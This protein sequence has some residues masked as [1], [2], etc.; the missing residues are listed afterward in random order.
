[1]YR[2]VDQK[3][4]DGEVANSSTVTSD[5]WPLHNLVGFTL[6]AI[7]TGSSIA[8]TAAI[9][10]SNDGTNWVELADS[11][12]ALSDS[13]NF[14]WEVSDTYAK[15]MRVKIVE[16]AGNDATCNVYLHARGK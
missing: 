2:I 15:Y 8:G 1:M 10:L 5:K 4:V 12:Q 13:L 11:S 7:V 6:Q 3:I 16:T 14:M 9:E